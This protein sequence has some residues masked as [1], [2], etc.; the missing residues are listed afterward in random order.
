M[1]DNVVVLKKDNFDLEISQKG[2]YLVDFW[3]QWCG[4]CKVVGPI[5]SEVADYF[6]GKA[7][8]GKVD[9]D[10]QGELASKFRI[11]SIPT[12]IIFK[13]GEVV[14]KLTGLKSKEEYI[15]KVQ[16]HL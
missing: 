5:I 12:I 6:V 7:K 11:V 16:E 9:V 1:E 4:P 10:E 15:S 13:D 14:D 2:V 8:I 3:A